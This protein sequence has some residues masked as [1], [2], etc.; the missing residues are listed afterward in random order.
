MRALSISAAWEETRAILARDGRLY[1]SV[2]LALIALPSAIN[3]LVNPGG[4]DSSAA[5][6]LNDVIAF[7]ATIITLAGQLALIRLAIGPS[8]TVG[9]AIVHGLRRTPFYI[10]AVICWCSPC[11]S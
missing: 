6:V 2:A 7:L 8:T 4:L 3:V 1:I 11:W 10:A 5:P 9:A